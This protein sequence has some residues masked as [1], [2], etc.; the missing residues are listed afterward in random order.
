MPELYKHDPIVKYLY[1]KKQRG[2]SNFEMMMVLHMC[3]VRKRISV[4]KEKFQE[5]KAPY[6]ITSVWMESETEGKRPYKQYFLKR[7][8]YET[9]C[10]AKSGKKRNTAKKR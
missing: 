10:S 1:M 9:K 6:D 5:Y 2:A 4:L 8:Q 3:D 7:T